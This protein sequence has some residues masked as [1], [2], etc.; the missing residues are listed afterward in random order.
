MYFTIIPADNTVYKNSKAYKEGLDLSACNIPSDVQA[1]QWDGTSGWIE[2]FGVVENQPI[3][4]LPQWANACLAAW[5][6]YDYAVNN[7]PAPTPEELASVNETKAKDLLV[8]SDWTQLP[9]V[10]LA[11]Q[12]EWDS[13]RQELRLIA[14]NPTPD[15]TWP[16]M[17][18]VIWGE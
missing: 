9:D 7:P 11:N 4:E 14:T 3:T 6:A 15:P 10:N 13:Y 2:F 1:L 18:P 8:A 16:I 5:E 17:P 12:A